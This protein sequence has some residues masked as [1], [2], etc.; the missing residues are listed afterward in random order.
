MLILC[1]S[2]IRLDGHVNQQIGICSKTAK[3]WLTC[4]EYKWK[5]VLKGIFFDGH[6]QKNVIEYR[7]TFLNEMQALLPYLVE[8]NQNRSIISKEYPK[9]CA[10]GSPNQKPVILITHDGST[11]SANNGCQKVWI[12]DGHGILR[13]K[14]KEK[15]IMVLDFFF[16]WS[17][18][19]FSFFP[20]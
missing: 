8:F 9:N 5:K 18:L 10:V 6:E 7:T 4:L 15:G 20:P 14:D 13:L 17:K 1:S 3:K 11:F 12:L 16:P 2:I 19:N